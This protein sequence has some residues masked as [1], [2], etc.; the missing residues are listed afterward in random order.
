MTVPL[1][2]SEIVEKIEALMVDMATTEV[3]M[4]DAKSP[5]DAETARRCATAMDALVLAYTS[6]SGSAA[7]ADESAQY[8]YRKAHAERTAR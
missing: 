2:R 8:A 7:Q 5:F 4:L 3:A 1:R 6:M